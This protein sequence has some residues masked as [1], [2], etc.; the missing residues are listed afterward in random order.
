MPG[1]IYSITDEKGWSKEG[2]YNLQLLKEKWIIQVVKK[3][4]KII[5]S[6]WN[7]NKTKLTYILN[8]HLKFGEPSRK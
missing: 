6:R 7:V 4:G 1:I 2:I 3:G 5:I 8:N